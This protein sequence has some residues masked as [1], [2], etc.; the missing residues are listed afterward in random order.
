MRSE[1][2]LLMV[3]VIIITCSEVQAQS[4][5]VRYYHVELQPNTHMP[6]YEK[7]QLDSIQLAH[8]ANIK[9]MAESGRL[10]VAGPFKDGGGLFILNVA[11]FAEAEQL[12]NQ[13]PAVMAGKFTYRI[14][15][16]YTE[17]GLFTLE[18][19]N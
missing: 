15:E 3:F 13:D 19:K 14:K 17:K 10:M 5:I 6:A 7:S 1:F 11:S 9:H 8:L 2:L 4:E 18:N 16:W 12:C